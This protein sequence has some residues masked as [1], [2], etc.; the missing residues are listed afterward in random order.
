MLP[1]GEKPI[2]DPPEVVPSEIAPRQ[3]MSQPTSPPSFSYLDMQQPET[4][5]QGL[6]NYQDRQLPTTTASGFYNLSANLNPPTSSGWTYGDS[7]RFTLPPF[8]SSPWND[9]IEGSIFQSTYNLSPPF[10]IET[11]YSQRTFPQLQNIWR[12]PTVATTLDETSAASNSHLSHAHVFDQ[13]V[14]SD[15]LSYSTFLNQHLHSQLNTVR[16]CQESKEAVATDVYESD[17]ESNRGEPPYAKLIY[18]ALMD[19]PEHRLVLRDIYAWISEN[20]DKARDPAFKGWQNSVRHNLSMNGAFRK[21]PYVDPANKHKRGFIWALEPSAVGRGIESTTRYRQ[22]TVAR[23]RENSEM[24]DPKRQRSGRK[25]GRA[26]RQSARLRRAAARMPGGQSQYTSFCDYLHSDTASSSSPSAINSPI[27]PEMSL[28]HAG[29]SP[30]Y[31]H[32]PITGSPVP[33]HPF[34]SPEPNNRD[35][36]LPTNQTYLNPP[37]LSPYDDLPDTKSENVKL[38]DEQDTNHLQADT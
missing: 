28:Y 24:T 14:W 13:A 21:M 31:L 34:Y 10:Q 20:T 4:D 5:S 12:T 35:V 8:P 2:L 30:Y 17:S 9:P 29:H 22:K 26:A 11:N 3:H 18:N 6:Y 37:F 32:T 23:S 33:D 36:G 15:P 1:V 38:K 7:N 25:G 19:A 16:P 27:S